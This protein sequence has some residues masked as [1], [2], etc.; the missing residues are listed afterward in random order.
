[1]TMLTTGVGG[2]GAARNVLQSSACVRFCQ[3]KP[4]MYSAI[5]RM[6]S[7]SFFAKPATTLPTAVL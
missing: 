5:V 3:S 7:A 6:L 1:M 2:V 4:W